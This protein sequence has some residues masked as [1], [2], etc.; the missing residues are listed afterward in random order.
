[1]S[2]DKDLGEA[3]EKLK[4][5]MFYTYRGVTYERVPEGWKHGHV[6]FTSLTDIDEHMDVMNRCL[7]KSLNRLKK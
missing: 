3:F 1:M 6:T 7:E 2:I 4:G 5:Q